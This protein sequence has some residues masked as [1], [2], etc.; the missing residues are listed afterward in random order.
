MRK[1]NE[2]QKNVRLDGDAANSG[3]VAASVFGMLDQLTSDA[4]T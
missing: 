4:T 3:I 2:I 1:F